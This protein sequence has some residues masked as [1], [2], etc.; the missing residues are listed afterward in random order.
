MYVS[1]DDVWVEVALEKG[2]IDHR[3]LGAKEAA[4]KPS[5]G[6]GFLRRLGPEKPTKGNRVKGALAH[7][8][9]EAENHLRRLHCY[10]LIILFDYL[11]FLAFNLIVSSFTKIPFPLYGS[12]TLHLRILAAKLITTSLSMPSSNILVGNGVLAFTPLGTPNSIGCEYPTLR[13]TKFCSGYSGLTVVALGST[14]A[15]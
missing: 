14:V 9:S 2:L 6:V 4:R 5:Q 8:T 3:S 10:P 7:P 11:I 13:E 15:R 1:G 12:G